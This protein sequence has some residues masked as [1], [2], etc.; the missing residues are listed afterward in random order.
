MNAFK[1]LAAVALTLS[2]NIACDSGGTEPDTDTD[3]DAGCDTGE[4]CDTSDTGTP[5][6][7]LK[8]TN[9]NP[10]L[11][12]G[13][14]DLTAETEDWTYEV[15]LNVFQTCSVGDPTANGWDEEHDVPSVG[16]T[17]T[18]DSLAVSLSH[19]ESA[20]S[21]TPGST[22]LFNIDDDNTLNYVLRVYGADGALA[23]CAIWGCNPDDVFN[24]NT[25]TWNNQSAT[26]E[27]T[28]QNCVNWN[29]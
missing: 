6:L 16:H 1:G 4:D 5:A 8:I 11:T 20:G 29:Q 26:S 14:Y 18:T 25:S 27:I 9:I 23:D 10:S 2:L 19:V 7:E 17:E 24:G 13:G 12:A 28:A 21:V 15:V 3:T 22:T